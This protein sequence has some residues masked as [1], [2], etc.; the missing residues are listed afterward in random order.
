MKQITQLV[1]IAFILMLSVTSCTKAN[2]TDI[3][4]LTAF[5]KEVI[6]YFK[7]VALGFEFG[8]ADIPDVTRKWNE[9]LK[10]FIDGEKPEVLLQ[11]L[12]KIIA[13]INTIAT[14][15]FK[16]SIVGDRFESNYYLFLGTAADYLQK[17]PSDSNLVASNY[18]LFILSIDDD[19]HFFS[20]RMYVDT[21]RADLPAQK[22]LLREELT[23]SLGLAK[24][25]YKYPESIFQSNW[26]V[27]NSYAEIDKALI[28][29]LYHPDM[30]TGLGEN[31]IENV[32]EAILLKD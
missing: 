22:H 3:K 5:D 19:N 25:S 11:E 10:V 29:L 30:Q 28:K 13:E 24:D 23:Q 14:D 21:Q 31:N 9:E 16:I 8:D 15:G 1:T 32:L 27:T 26:T 18:G 6:S 4:E 20:G 7:E 17:Y 12:N 2:D